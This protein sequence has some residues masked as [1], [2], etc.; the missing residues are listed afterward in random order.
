MGGGGDRGRRGKWEDKY[1]RFGS[2]REFV[3]PLLKWI[4]VSE[5]FFCNNHIPI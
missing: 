2:H 5:V 4:P 1:V 3:Y